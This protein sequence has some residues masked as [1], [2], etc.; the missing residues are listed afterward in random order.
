MKIFSFLI[1][2]I[3]VLF[4]SFLANATVINDEISKKYSQI[5]SQN[6]LNDRDVENY[7]KIFEYQEVCKWKKANKYILEIENDIL[8]GHIL[9]QR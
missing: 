9:A 5:F 7:K 2:I 1:F 3:S 8:M 6:I 4:S